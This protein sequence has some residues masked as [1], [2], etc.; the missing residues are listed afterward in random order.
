MKKETFAQA[1]A[2]ILATL[3]SAGWTVATHHQGRPMK[4]PHATSPNGQKRYW[5]HPQAVY[6]TD[7]SEF[8][9][10]QHGE[11]RSLHLEMRGLD[12]SELVRQAG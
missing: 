2:R 1:T 9:T 3:K 11:A 8:K 5:F 4:T 10:H 6:F 7:L 12:T